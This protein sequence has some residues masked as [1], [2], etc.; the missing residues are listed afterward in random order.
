MSLHSSKPSSHLSRFVEAQDRSL[1]GG[2]S[3][4]D[5]ALGELRNGEKRSHWIWFIFPQLKGLGY[6]PMASLYGIKGLAE[7][8]EYLEHP[9]LSKRLEESFQVVLNQL[10]SPSSAS[11]LLAANVDR[12]MGGRTDAV[13]LV[14]CATLFRSASKSPSLSSSEVSLKISDLTD[15]ILKCIE[16]NH[17]LKPC[18]FTLREV[19]KEQQ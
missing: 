10:V 6:S 9:I 5:Q 16:E 11:S 14:S 3:Q 13:K 2:K 19:A 7:A 17:H 12:L 15:K 4:F 1:H 18:Q 8:V